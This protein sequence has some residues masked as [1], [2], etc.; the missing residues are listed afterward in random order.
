MLIYFLVNPGHR[1]TPC[2][3]TP[4][5]TPINSD[6]SAMTASNCLPAHLYAQNAYRANDFATEKCSPMHYTSSSSSSSYPGHHHH[7]HQQ[8]QQQHQT[9]A[10]DLYTDLYNG[11][12]NTCGQPSDFNVELPAMA[13]MPNVYNVNAYGYE[14]HKFNPGESHAGYFESEKKFDVTTGIDGSRNISVPNGY[15]HYN[16]CWLSRFL[17][18]TL[19]Q[20]IIHITHTHTLP[21]HKHKQANDQ[22]NTPTE[23]IPFLHFICRSIT[24]DYV[25]N[26]AC[27]LCLSNLCIFIFDSINLFKF[28]FIFHSM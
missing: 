28:Y 20:P 5:S 17:G 3:L 15:M 7:H 4:P 6:L 2:V 19:R 27:A 10:V 23:Q 18:V 25:P 1:R 24:F 13:E 8:P 22:I 26:I 12:N 16:N 21:L 14:S 11:Y 9:T